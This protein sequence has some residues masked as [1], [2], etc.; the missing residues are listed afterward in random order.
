MKAWNLAAKTHTA[1]F[2]EI[3]C[4]VLGEQGRGRKQTLV[5]CPLNVN[6]GDQVTVIPSTSGKPK[7]VKKDDNKESWLMRI[8][9]SGAYIRGAKGNVR[10]LSQHSE[11]VNLIAK[12][13]GAFGDAGGVG[14]WDD[15][16]AEVNSNTLLRV[17][18]SRGDAYFLHVL[19]DTVHKITSDEIDA[20]D[21]AIST[22]LDDY[23][24][25]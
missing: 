13:S 15:V 22:N 5:P 7:V 21:Y 3:E 8:S 4:L 20:Y 11:N 25:I 6:N 10:V 1:S 19:E 18:P 9:T 23:I 17:K 2:G 12:G 16:L 14:T 24:R